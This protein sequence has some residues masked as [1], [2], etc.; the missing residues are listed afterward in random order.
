MSGNLVKL[1]VFL[2]FKS[3]LS[4]SSEAELRVVVPTPQLWVYMAGTIDVVV[5]I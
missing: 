3:F 2:G 4:S 1:L 5:R